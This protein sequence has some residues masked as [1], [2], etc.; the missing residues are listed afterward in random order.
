[1]RDRVV[2][3][4]VVAGL[5][6]QEVVILDATPVAAEDRVV[7]AQVSAP[8][9]ILPLCSATISTTFSAASHQQMKDS[10]FRY[11][12]PM[13]RVHVDTEN[14]SQCAEVISAP[15]KAAC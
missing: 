3:G 2:D 10:R 14:A 4:L 5:E 8:A 12:L 13:S 6:M 1:M 9:T 15:L 11:G 7:A